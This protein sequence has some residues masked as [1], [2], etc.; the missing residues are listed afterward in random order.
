MMWRLVRNATTQ[1]DL[2]KWDC[3]NAAQRK[4]FE[5]WCNDRL[6]ELVLP[7]DPDLYQVSLGSIAPRYVEFGAEMDGSIA[8]YL[9][10]VAETEH[11]ERVAQRSARRRRKLLPG[12]MAGEPRPRDLPQE[13]HARLEF[14]LYEL[15]QLRDIWQE[16]Y[17]RSKRRQSPLAMNIICRRWG[18]TPDRIET[19]RKNKARK[20][21][22]S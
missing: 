20:L 22:A 2:P 6:D 1:V 12:R 10:F 5:A 9:K 18:L 8:R 14:A 15:V 16:H 21:A 17:K 13:L 19:Y 11:R 4:A 3:I 7:G